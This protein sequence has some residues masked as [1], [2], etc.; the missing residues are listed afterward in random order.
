MEKC[1]LRPPTRPLQVNSSKKIVYGRRKPR[2]PAG[3]LDGQKRRAHVPS[4]NPGG[5]P[6]SPAEKKQAAARCSPA[7]RTTRCGDVAGLYQRPLR[8]PMRPVDEIGI[9]SMLYLC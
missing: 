4:R 3:S 9:V 8:L 6:R 5:T 2:H 1:F 7:S